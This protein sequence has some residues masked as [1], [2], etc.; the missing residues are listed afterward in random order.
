MKNK[1]DVFFKNRKIDLDIDVI[2]DG[3]EILDSGGGI[4]NMIKHSNEE[5][6]L[7]LNP[8][9]IWNESYAKSI[10]E[11]EKIY[12]KNN[13]QNILLVVNKK[14]SFDKSLTGDFK[15]SK[16]FLSKQEPRDFIYTGCQIINKSMFA[17]INKNKFSINFL[18]DN[19]LHTNKLFGFESKDQ[20]FHITDLKIYKDLL[21]N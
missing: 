10:K 8:D 6:F 3:K 16:N 18:W 21:E 14:L 17:N 15:L 4:L 12:F 11:M 7:V 2:S 19:L 5:H 20:F 13:L 9:T 1:I